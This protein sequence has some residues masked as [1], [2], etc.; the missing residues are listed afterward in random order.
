[1]ATNRSQVALLEIGPDAEWESDATAFFL[2]NI[3]RVNFG[4]DYESALY[5]VGG[6]PEA[7]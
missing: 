5:L 1:M 3:T 7:G 2:K 4:G 6:D